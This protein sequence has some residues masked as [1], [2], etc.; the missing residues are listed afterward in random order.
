[1]SFNS[2]GESTRLVSRVQSAFG[3][4]EAA[5]E[6]GFRLLPYHE[7]SPI[8]SED[9]GRDDAMRGDRNP[10][11][12]VAGLINLAGNI[13]VPMGVQSIGWH[14]QFLFGDPVTTGG[15][16]DYV[17]TFRPAANPTPR[18]QTIGKAHRDIGLQYA[19]DSLLY[20]GFEVSAKKDNQRARMTFP[21]IGR[22]EAKLGAE[23]DTTPVE[24]ADDVVPVNFTGAVLVDG[25]SAAA[26]TEFSGK[27]ANG[28]E[29]DQE[30]MN[31]AATASLM[32]IGDWMSDGSIATRFR[33]ATFLDLASNGTLIDLSLEYVIT[34]TRGITLRFNNV[35]LERTGV[36]VSGRGASS[37]SFNWQVGRPD[38]GTYPFEIELRNDVASY[39]N[40][41]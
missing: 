24:F 31:G 39:A 12:I 14:L 4:A 7:Y 5:V 22:D 9:L 27:V 30:E 26:I 34:A 1:M 25:V 11:D 37:A 18:L 32:D 41:T 15:P 2:H 29:P 21:I 35:R 28:A 6:G 19:H 17:H 33:D 36:P 38:T 3:T 16:T 23:L 20:T 8:P 13:V 40:P 10:G